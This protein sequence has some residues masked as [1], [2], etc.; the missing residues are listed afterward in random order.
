[1]ACLAG[2]ISCS[3]VAT[4]FVH[5]MCRFHLLF[6]TWN[7]TK[8]QPD[9]RATNSD[10]VKGFPRTRQQLIPKHNVTKRRMLSEVMYVHV[11]IYKTGGTTF[12]RDVPSFL[13][14]ASCNKHF[15]VGGC[16]DPPG[17]SKFASYLQQGS[18]N[19]SCNF[20]SYE[21]SLQNLSKLFKPCNHL[22]LRFV[23]MIRDPFM[24][25]ISAILHDVRA[26]RFQYAHDKIDAK[27]YKP[28]YDLAKPFTYFLNLNN[29]TIWEAFSRFYFI[30]ITEHYATSICLLQ[31][32]HVGETST[33]NDCKF[34]QARNVMT[35]TIE[36][37]QNF[38]A[39][40]IK[41]VKRVVTVEEQ[42]VYTFALIQLMEVYESN[43]HRIY[44][45]LNMQ[46][47]HT[48]CN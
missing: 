27:N 41:K 9:T 32:K 45:N 33:L 20:F 38:S 36:E 29:G 5:W 14:L 19:L 17:L 31:Y 15:N 39:I 46:I 30:G 40:D 21:A 10:R 43:G 23:T 12:R 48:L 4:I 35:P 11:H 1:M 37:S 3:T 47:P 28:G 34:D 22:D 18:C 16:C 13:G 26:K 44:K 6:P 24:W 25:R 8:G 42:I 7:Y 2:S